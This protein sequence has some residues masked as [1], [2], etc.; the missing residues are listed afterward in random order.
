L[1]RAGPGR[2][3]TP[4][5]PRVSPVAISYCAPFGAQTRS[6]ESGQAS[7]MPSPFSRRHSH[8]PL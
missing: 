1:T 7:K 3:V 4:A 5:N 6:R 8:P 2:N